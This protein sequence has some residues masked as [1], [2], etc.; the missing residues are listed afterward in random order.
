[1]PQRPVTSAVVGWIAAAVV[2]AG[3]SQG[4]LATDAASAVD[5]HAAADTTSSTDRP[6]TDAT[7]STDRPSATDAPTSP[8]PQDPPFFDDISPC[9][10]LDQTCGYLGAC[11]FRSFVCA[12][13]AD[14]APA[15]WICI[16]DCTCAAAGPPGGGVD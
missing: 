3:C 5:A 14:G 9:A 7:S 6:S 16:G 4:T 8:C 10:P 2:A 1:M 12:A 15:R 13:I 11:G